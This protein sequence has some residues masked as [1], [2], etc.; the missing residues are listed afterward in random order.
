[1]KEFQLIDE[2]M[3]DVPPADQARTLAVRARLL[4]GARRRRTPR[5][6]WL[7]AGAAVVSVLVAGFLA[8][9]RLGDGTV[10]TA[11]APDAAT[12]L[13]AALD[14]LAV[15]PPGGGARWRRESLE[16]H[17]S[18]PKDAYTVERRIKD[19]V[20]RD[21]RTV[22][23][24]RT[25]LS[26]EPLTAADRRAWQAAGSPPLCVAE[27]PCRFGK[28]RVETLPADG[29]AYPVGPAARL[30]ADPEALRAHLLKV[31]PQGAPESRESFL[32]NLAT[33]LLKDTE[34]TPAT[35]AA[36][37]RMLAAFPGVTVAD[38]VTD[39]EGRVGV[40]LVQPPRE[41]HMQ[42]LI[43]LD[44]ESGELLGFQEVLLKPSPNHADIRPGTPYRWE[45]IRSLG[46]TDEAP[47]G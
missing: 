17:L 24:E 27:D 39:V 23:T 1:M 42:E 19:V 22:R 36:V 6:S 13:D 43:L 34:I 14:R 18:R 31:Y 10:H 33:Y 38:G 3:P 44:R 11:K 25:D 37:Y 12:V 20:W 32:W 16:V 40:A 21:G 28:A 30:P 35:R 9:P 7:L 2:V 41:N 45:L 4:G 5:L 8:I 47:T 46:W 15:R 26:A 29:L